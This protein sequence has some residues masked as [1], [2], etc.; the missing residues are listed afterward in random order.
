MKGIREA[1]ESHFPRCDP[2]VDRVAMGKPRRDARPLLP[3]E[4]EGF[5]V[6]DVNVES[7]SRVHD[8]EV[9]PS[10]RKFVVQ[11]GRLTANLPELPVAE[12]KALMASHLRLDVSVDRAIEVLRIQ[13][14]CE[15]LPV[16]ESTPPRM[17]IVDAGFADFLQ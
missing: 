17:G 3:G 4:P 8:F 5:L 12:R 1:D 11:G 10:P 2:F 6:E 15:L 16:E 13:V 7:T 14:E 9:P